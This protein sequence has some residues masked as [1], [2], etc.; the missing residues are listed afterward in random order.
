VSA[1]RERTITLTLSEAH[2]RRLL[3][4]VTDERDQ[5]DESIGSVQPMWATW[6]TDLAMVRSVI[7]QLSEALEHDDASGGS[8]ASTD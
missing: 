6:R 5:I 8:D 7:D 1:T 3:A 2:A 4:L